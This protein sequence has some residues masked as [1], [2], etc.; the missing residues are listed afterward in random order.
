MPN[1]KNPFARP[2]NIKNSVYAMES[3]DKDTVDLTF[4]GDVVAEQPIDWWTGEPIEGNYISMDAF[5]KD[6]D[7]LSSCKNIVI[8]MN[9]YGGDCMAG[10]AIHNKLREFSRSGKK[11]T[12][13]VDGVAMSSASLIMSA[14]DTVKVN[15]T[16]LVMVH[17]CWTSVFG[18]YNADELA[19]MA[20]QN[21]TYDKAIA[22]AYVRK[23]GIS[24][25]EI[26][27]MMGETTY[28]TGAEAVEKGF[29]DELLEGSEPVQISA[30][31]DGQ[32]LFV[33]N[34]RL[35]LAPGTAAPDY[36][37]TMT[38]VSTASA[39]PGA[40]NN[41]KKPD[42]PGNPKG[43]KTMTRDE[44]KAQY[45]DMYAEIV[46]EATANNAQASADAV[47]AERQRIAG[48][49]EI[50]G[51]YS[52]DA[53][54]DAKYGEGACTAGE[55]ALRMA[56]E[57]AKKGASFMNALEADSQASGTQNVQSA[58]A[59]P[60]PTDDHHDMTEAEVKGFMANIFKK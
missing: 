10:F 2:F 27:Q 53:V 36:I 20:E 45:P 44:F 28:L 39:Q 56:K 34:K 15:P 32:M 19:K 30:S 52:S 35:R 1:L 37:P 26:L 8:H 16:S 25:E 22:S 41:T 55:L 60:T 42:N 24:E 5:M 47:A 12:C 33:Q 21:A 43:G 7:R 48:I 50:A 31:A 3:A 4:Y 49:D 46:A 38:E 9:S 14:C 23:T 51:L 17:K 54:N 29:A 58:V 40:A 18:G 6:L 11:L 13:I 57:A 59:E